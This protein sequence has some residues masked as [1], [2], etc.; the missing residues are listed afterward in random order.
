MVMGENAETSVSLSFGE[1]ETSVGE[2]VVGDGFPG[3]A[4]VPPPPPPPHPG[5]VMPMR[6]K[7]TI[8]PLNT[9]RFK[10]NLKL[11]QV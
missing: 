2:A 1:T 5:R 11:F 8:N 10:E 6:D 7:P 4:A 9:K 3:P